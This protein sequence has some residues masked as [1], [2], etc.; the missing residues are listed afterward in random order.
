MDTGLECRF[1]LQDPDRKDHQI[2]DHSTGS[3]GNCNYSKIFV[4]AHLITAT[5]KL[6]LCNVKKKSISPHLT[7]SQKQ[8]FLAEERIRFQPLVDIT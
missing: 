3:M 7:P 8:Q 4:T 6:K 1:L 5:G 2:V